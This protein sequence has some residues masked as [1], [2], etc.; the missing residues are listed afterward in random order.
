[1][2]GYMRSI[3]DGVVGPEN[4]ELVLSLIYGRIVS[5]D[6]PPASNTRFLFDEVMEGKH[7]TILGEARTIVEKV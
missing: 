7:K 1:M 4:G 3:V 6:S 2:Y 5:K